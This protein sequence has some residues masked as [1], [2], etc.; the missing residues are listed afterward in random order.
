MTSQL[1][2]EFLKLINYSWGQQPIQ[3][4][5]QQ[6]SLKKQNNSFAR[7]SGGSETF[8]KGGGGHPDPEIRGGGPQK[9]KLF[10]PFWPHFRLKIRRGGPPDPSPGSATAWIKLLVEHVFD[11]SIHYTGE[12]SY[13][14]VLRRTGTLGEELFF[15]F[16]NSVNTDLVNNSS[17]IFGIIKL[18]LFVISQRLK[19]P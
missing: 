10:R 1:L 12:T 4:F 9:K 13:S 19:F 6:F 18:K 3:Q 2:H 17:K 8:R 11:I 16:V 14:N 15:S 7:S 5:R